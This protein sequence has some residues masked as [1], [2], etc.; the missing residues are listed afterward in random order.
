MRKRNTDKPLLGGEEWG[1]F[2]QSGQGEPMLVSAAAKL[3]GKAAHLCV[4]IL[5]GSR[6]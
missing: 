5:W 2:S 4:L 3:W 1:Q 6:G